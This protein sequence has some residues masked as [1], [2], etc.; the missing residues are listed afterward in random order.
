MG[1]SF[2]RLSLNPF[3]LKAMDQN[4]TTV[5]Q[6][7][8]CEATLWRCENKHSHRVHIIHGPLAKILT[9]YPDDYCLTFLG[10]KQACLSYQKPYQQAI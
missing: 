5:T 7:R 2:H 9:D 6:N 4:Q 10:D 3:R 8:Y 1:S